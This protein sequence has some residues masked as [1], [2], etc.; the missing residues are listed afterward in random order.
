LIHARHDQD[1]HIDK[2][3]VRIRHI[4]GYRGTLLPRCTANTL[5]CQTLN[6][7]MMI[8][9]LATTRINHQPWIAINT[10]THDTLALQNE[11]RR[12]AVVV[13]V[14]YSYSPTK[15]RTGPTSRSVLNQFQNKET[16]MKNGTNGT[17]AAAQ[18]TPKTHSYSWV[19]VPHHPLTVRTWNIW[20]STAQQTT[21]P[22]VPSKVPRKYQAKSQERSNSTRVFSFG[23]SDRLEKKHCRVTTVY[24]PVRAMP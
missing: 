3:S 1:N 23:Q 5:I 4:F 15:P 14:L 16:G 2:T 7:P 22:T 21:T 8:Q 13:A 24:I 19:A 18:Q 9:G 12:S 20:P 6:N 17:A 10:V 11:Q